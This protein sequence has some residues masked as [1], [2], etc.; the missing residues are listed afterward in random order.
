MIPIQCWQVHDDVL[1]RSRGTTVDIGYAAR[2]TKPDWPLIR[3]NILH[4]IIEYAIKFFPSK[5]VGWKSS[6]CNSCP[7][8]TRVWP[9]PNSNLWRRSAKLPLSSPSC[10]ING[11][12]LPWDTAHWSTGIAVWRDA[13]QTAVPRH[14]R[15]SQRGRRRHQ[16]L[17]CYTGGCMMIHCSYQWQTQWILDTLQEKPAHTGPESAVK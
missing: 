7:G 15:V 17:S 11:N 9:G 5:K 2:E 12:W 4:V 13:P 14:G 6:T 10:A 16:E 3:H 8:L 1:L